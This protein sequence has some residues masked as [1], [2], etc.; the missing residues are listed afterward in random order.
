MDYTVRGDETGRMNR[1]AAPIFAALGVAW[2]IP[3]LLIKI[4]V[5]QLDPSQVVLAR[6]ALAALILLPIAFARGALRPVLPYWRPLVLFSVIEIVIPWLALTRAETVLPS[7]TAGLL[8]AA[9]PL[10]GLVVA[11]LSGRAEHLSAVNWAG[12]ALGILGVAALVGLDVSG[13][14]LGGVAEIALTVVGYALGPAILARWL[15]HLPGLGVTTLALSIAAVIYTPVVLLGPGVPAH[16]PAGR[17]L[18]SLVVLAV[19]CT[20]AAFLLLFALIGEIG[21]MRATTITYVNPAVAVVGGVVILN[22]HATLW[23]LAGFVLVIAGSVLVN[24][25]RSAGPAVGEPVP[26]AAEAAA[27][28]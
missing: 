15:G 20:A 21:P 1:R 28:P 27:C 2:G 12:L 5:E 25:R 6:T 11:Y 26:V 24:S 19:V 16:L 10:V 4:A 18:V 22:E 17:I 3:Y 23:T 8:I 14:D 9:V 13:S 7:S